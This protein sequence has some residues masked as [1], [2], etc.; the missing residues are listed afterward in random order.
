MV[1]NTFENDSRVLKESQ[2]LVKAG[3][4]VTVL[5]LKGENLPNEVSIGGVKVNRIQRFVHKNRKTPILNAFNLLCY[6]FK[7]AWRS[8]HADII[9]CNDLNTLPAG[10]L[11]KILLN[12][13]IGLLYDAHEFE[14]NRK[15]N[16]AKY[17]I[18]LWQ[19][20][21]RFYLRFT[22][23]VI[24]VSNAIAEEY[25]KLY[26]IDKPTL[27]LNCPPYQKVKKHDLFRE[28]L[29]IRPEQKIFLYQGGFAPNRGIENILKAFKSLDN[30]KN[31]LVL[32]GYGSLESLVLE[33]A[34]ISANIFYHP[35][36]YPDVLLSYTAS[37]DV[38]LLFYENNCL[39]HYY[40]SPNK[41]FEYIMA[42][43]PVIGSNLYEMKKI[44]EEYG[45]GVIVPENTPDGISSTILGLRQDD[46]DRFQANI[47]KARQIYKWENQEANLL[48]VYKKLALP[49]S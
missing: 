32:M 17:I 36:V 26:A 37:A 2:S 40:C 39:N 21:E 46:L 5:C 14:S 10:V 33:H 6:Q 4:S 45:I 41:M 43:L 34:A 3:L 31:V 49:E 35:A 30:D 1:A 16:Q 11:A 38:G 9:H 28:K 48:E 7:A 25:A 29:G 20:F 15:A 13:R 22:D 42:G 27:V 23:A 19:F 8:R 18:K 44:V 47:D 12:H 24:T